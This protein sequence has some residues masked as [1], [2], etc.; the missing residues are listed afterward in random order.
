MVENM[1]WEWK[2]Y[3]LRAVLENWGDFLKETFGN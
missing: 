2:K 1:G 3:I